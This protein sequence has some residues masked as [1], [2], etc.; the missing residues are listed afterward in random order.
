M[1]IPQE[2][3]DYNQWV[4]WRYE[5]RNGTKP[6]KVP[7]C[8]HT[9]QRAAVDNH[10]T[11]GSFVAALE[12]LEKGYDG[13]GFILTNDDPFAFVDFD[14]TD[15]AS[16]M[17]LQKRLFA[18][19]HSYA[20]ISPSG[21]GLH[22]ICKGSIPAGRRRGSI[23]VYTS[24]RYMTMTGNVY[25]QADIQFEQ[26]FVQGIY[27]MLGGDK[28]DKRDT[29]GWQEATEDDE[30][31]YSKAATAA[32]G[33]KFEALYAGN[34]Q[35][36]Y[37]SQSEA[38]MALINIIAYYTDSKAQVKRMFLASELGK[39]DKAQRADYVGYML[40]RCH[41]NRLPPIDLEKMHAQF[42]ENM[43][44]AAEAKDEDYEPP[45]EMTPERAIYSVPDGLVGEIA[46]YI[47]AQSHFP[48]P[49]IALSGALALMS[50]ICGRAF[51]V[52][53]TG[54][55]NYIVLLA[56]TGT[57]KEAMAAG[58]SNIVRAAGQTV[59]SAD[60]FMA[61]GH[62]ASGISMV[63]HLSGTSKSCLSV[64]GEFGLMLKQMRA[65]R[66][67]TTQGQELR[68]NLLDLYNKS[69]KGN[70]FMG[71][72]YSDRDKNIGV[73]QAPAFSFLG[74]STA[75]RF[76]ETIDEGLMTEGFVPRLTI[77]DYA[78]KKPYPNQNRIPEPSEELIGKVR[79][80]MTTALS[81]NNINEVTD[82][83]FTPGAREMADDFNLYTIDTQNA[84]TDDTVAQI[85]SRVYVKVLKLAALV[86]VG[87]SPFEPVITADILE[88]SIA[89]NEHSAK[90]LLHKF[91]SGQVGETTET[92]C[93]NRIREL[94]TKWRTG[95]SEDIPSYPKHVPN[96]S[97]MR[98]E[99]VMPRP[100]LQS[101]TCNYKAFKKSQ[102]GPKAAL[103]DAL[104]TEV[105]N[106]VLERVP[107]RE[108]R[109]KY[110]YGGSAWRI[111]GA[112]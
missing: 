31:I 22:I 43:A 68:R 79:Q 94:A 107:E 46:Q 35:Q 106:G 25:R 24:G 108:L 50:G 88:W 87:K 85:W 101:N 111:I 58:I 57:G 27:D 99:W 80:L 75:M 65:D 90:R 71:A 42:R 84:S 19:S 55:N 15:D 12:T 76:D 40:N 62:F 83:S 10:R 8:P 72:A 97:K 74:E 64:F 3:R 54:L 26:K 60:E 32:N 28:N 1:N 98:D 77:I 93:V 20:E 69:G 21:N 13:L 16:A 109:E 6:T 48:V 37:S 44:E 29:V 52:S 59:P 38:D 91:Q 30:V 67:G 100:Y 33:D 17:Q 78:G 104:H 5:D 18:D 103:E 47:Y 39:R 11:W 112:T 95:T 49:E 89:I 102:R 41:D 82:V 34:W 56:P 86:A 81:L 63:K 92:A 53:G 23:E 45:I 14:A 110:N 51:N 61:P 4:V 9:G 73:I 2:L 7:Y 105:A 66:M 36:D 96:V 70:A